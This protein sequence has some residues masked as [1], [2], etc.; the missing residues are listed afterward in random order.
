MAT[1]PA[2]KDYVV[3]F[4]RGERIYS[5]G[6]PGT[7]MYI[8]QSG[9]VVIFSEAGGKRIELAS[10]EKGDFFGEMALIESAPHSSSAEAAS[11]CELIEINST[12]FDKMIKGNI[13]IAV[14]MLR[15]LS[16]RLRDATRRV[17]E[18][19]AAGPRAAAPAGPATVA[20]TP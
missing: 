2:F 13:E 5:A 20:I 18:M 9:T 4:R 10:M 7:E 12:L 15:K 1:P 19:A 17:E 16:I 6:D 11:D 8:V 3:R 14:R